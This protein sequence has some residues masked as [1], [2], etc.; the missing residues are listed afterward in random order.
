MPIRGVSAL[1]FCG[2][3]ELIRLRVS[4]LPETSRMDKSVTKDTNSSIGEL[5]RERQADLSPAERKLARVLLASYPIAGLESVARF[6]ERARVSPPT[7]TRFI[8][9]LGFKGYPEFQ[10]ILRHEVQARISS[11]LARFRDEEPSRGAETLLTNVV[12]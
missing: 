5:V 7:V 3:E 11:P 8:T 12:D 6:A 10:E 1:G 4:N 9:K 2:V